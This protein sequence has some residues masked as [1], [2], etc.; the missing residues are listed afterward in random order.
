LGFRT[1]I[2]QLQTS[3]ELTKITKPISTE[4]EVAS[5]IEAMGEK[6]VLFTNVKESQIPVVGGLVS[7]K[8]LIARAIGTTRDKLL[9]VLSAAIEKPVTPRLV[10]KGDRKSV[11]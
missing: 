6:P 3:G 10:D 8:D 2:E 5:V 4:Y 9:P 1:F 11:V 7:S